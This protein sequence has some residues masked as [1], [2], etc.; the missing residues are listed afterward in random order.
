MRDMRRLVSDPRLYVLAGICGVAY[1]V[2]MATGDS[3]IWLAVMAVAFLV[4]AVVIDPHLSDKPS[5]PDQSSGS[6]P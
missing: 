6:K 3:V 1:F 2:T 4:L 5:D